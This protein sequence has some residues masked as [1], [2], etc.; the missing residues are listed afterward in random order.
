MNT[1]ELSEDPF[2][3]LHSILGNVAEKLVDRHLRNQA[4]REVHH[5]EAEVSVPGVGG[6]L[7]HELQGGAEGVHFPAAV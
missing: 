7:L 4:V 3:A 1:G 5:P 2:K 6:D